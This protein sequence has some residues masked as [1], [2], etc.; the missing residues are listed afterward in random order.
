MNKSL[1]VATLLAVALTACGKK[2]EVAAT[3]PPPVSAPSLVN[4]APTIEAPKQAEPTTQPAAG[5]AAPVVPS[6]ESSP[7]R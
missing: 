3:L 1:L 2:E 6:A 4:T 7:A 5:D